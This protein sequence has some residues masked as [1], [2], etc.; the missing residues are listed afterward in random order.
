MSNFLMGNSLWQ[1]VVQSDS[2]SKLVLWILLFLSIA[3]WSVFLYKV[4]LLR[5]KVKHMKK[6][7]AAIK[8]MNSLDDMLTVATQLADTIPGYFLSKNLTY[9]KSLLEAQ[10]EQGKAELSERDWDLLQHHMFGTVDSMIHN[11]ESYIALLSTSAAIS[12]LLGLFGTVWGLVHSFIRISEKQMA[13]IT[14]VAPGIAEALIT[15][16]AGLIVAIP[17]L[18]MY[19]YLLTQIRHLEQQYTVFAERIGLVVQRLLMRASHGTIYAQKKTGEFGPD[20]H[21]SN[22]AH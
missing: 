7:F 6:A 16:L 15:T 1:L 3:C 17:A 9:L 10:K 2:V 19:N 12:P 21:S 13:D 22:A 18:V 5:L 20:R 11:D 14:T 4:V 8:A